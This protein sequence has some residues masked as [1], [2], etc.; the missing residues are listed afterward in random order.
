MIDQLVFKE[1]SFGVEIV[2]FSNNV[3]LAPELWFWIKSINDHN[4]LYKDACKYHT[5]KTT[6]AFYPQSEIL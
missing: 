3:L 5:L 1:N 6:R 2:F 4:A